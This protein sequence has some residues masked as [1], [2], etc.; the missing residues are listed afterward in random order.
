MDLAKIN[1]VIADDNREFCNILK[2][3]FSGEKDIEVSGVVHDGRAALEAI[4]ERKPDLIILDMVMPYLD[5]LG[6]LERLNDMNSS[7]RPKIIALSAIGQDSITHRAIALGA[8]YYMVKPFDMS[9][10]LNRIRE[11][12]EISK[13]SEEVTTKQHDRD[14]AGMSN[15]KADDNGSLE[16]R[17]SEIIWRIGIPA[18]I[19][20]YK[21]I[22]D[23]IGMVVQNVELLSSITKILYPTIAEKYH[24]TPSRVERSI[25]HAIEIVWNRGQ[26]EELRDIFG[27]TLIYS[28]ERPTNSEFIAFIA[29]HIKLGSRERNY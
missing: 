29:D 28:K 19:Y 27:T 24:T 8:D 10:L 7:Y 18:H 25:R 17:I 12:F 14:A 22:R 23:A 3:Y 1:V 16:D 9:V 2:D 20:G 4:Q 21:Y 11:M 15:T 5:G 13:T 26:A 6:V